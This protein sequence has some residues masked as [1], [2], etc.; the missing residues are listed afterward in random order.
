D[1]DGERE[2]SAAA[3][4]SP[5]NPASDGGW[6]GQEDGRHG[7]R[8]LLAPDRIRVV[9]HGE[10]RLHVRLRIQ[11]SRDRSVPAAVVGEATMR[12]RNLA[13][14]AAIFAA[15]TIARSAIAADDRARAGARREAQCS[16]TLEAD[17]SLSASIVDTPLDEALLRLAHETGATITWTERRSGA[18]S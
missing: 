14:V 2:V 9:V 12:F 17:G 4:Q 16:I 18:R 7:H 5:A 13:L 15:T 8:N 11:P 10:G 3:P 6:P 1:R